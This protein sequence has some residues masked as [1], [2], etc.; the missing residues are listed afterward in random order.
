M[1]SSSALS[2]FGKIPFLTLGVVGVFASFDDVFV[3]S[4]TW[5]K[6]SSS[7]ATLVRGLLLVRRAESEEGLYRSMVL[8]G[9]DERRDEV[10]GAGGKAPLSA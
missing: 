10:A 9:R 5:L 4:W 6:R 1:V 2:I 3:S 7:V 8:K